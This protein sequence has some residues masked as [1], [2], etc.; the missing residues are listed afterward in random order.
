VDVDMAFE[1]QELTG[2]GLSLTIVE[3]K[4]EILAMDVSYDGAAQ[5]PPQHYHPSQA[6]RFTVLA[7]HMHTV[8]DG[9]ERVYAEGDSFDVPVA[10]RHQM[11]P[12][13]GPARVLWEVRPAQRT[14][15][16]FETLYTGKV[17]ENFLTEFSNEIRFG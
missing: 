15:D 2:P 8:I 5:M 3:L 14:A 17:N 12:H 13:D 1:G 9:V 7:G 4:P 16:F 6:E 11:G 10:A